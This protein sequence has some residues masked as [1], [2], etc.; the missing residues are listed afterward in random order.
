MSQPAG[1]LN[2]PL[3][4]TN[5][6][7]GLSSHLGLDVSACM[8]HTSEVQIHTRKPHTRHNDTSFG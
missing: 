6:Y 5:I 2:S 8:T 3:I 4:N 1:I 7:L